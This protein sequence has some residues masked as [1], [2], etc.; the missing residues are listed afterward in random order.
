MSP[1][2]KNFPKLITEVSDPKSHLV[3]IHFGAH[4]S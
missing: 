3:K 2:K 4:F 1:S